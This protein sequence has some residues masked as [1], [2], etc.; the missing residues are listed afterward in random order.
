MA[1]WDRRRRQGVIDFS[2]KARQ[3]VSTG[4]SCWSQASHTARRPGCSA[5]TVRRTNAIVPPDTAGKISYF[6]SWACSLGVVIGAGPDSIDANAP[7]ISDFRLPRIIDFPPSTAKENAF[8][9]PASRLQIF[10]FRDS[11]CATFPTILH[12]RVNLDELLYRPSAGGLT[13]CPGLVRW[14]INCS[15]PSL[16]RPEAV[17]VLGVDRILSTTNKVKGNCHGF[18]HNMGVPSADT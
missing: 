6:A 13:F 4:G 12:H 2:G 11:N 7:W 5:G 17:H 14:H 3:E 10:F 1:A 9:F 16:I 18:D 8:T 15:R